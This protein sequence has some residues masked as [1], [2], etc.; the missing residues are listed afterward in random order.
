M[1]KTLQTR[2]LAFALVAATLAASTPAWAA[3]AADVNVL[4]I[5]STR[6]SGEMHSASGPAWNKSRK[7]V[8][9]P[10]SSA[11]NPTNIASELQSILNGAGLGTV[12]VTVRE[13]YAQDM[14]A[15]GYNIA[16]SYTLASWFHYPYPAG[17]ETTRW[18]DLRG[19]GPRADRRRHP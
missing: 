18:A 9:P 8:F 10:D 19:A 12:N 16:Y 7:A 5:G 13:R 11:F 3:P 1:D 6:D 15:W 2:L 17:V 4:I 14:I